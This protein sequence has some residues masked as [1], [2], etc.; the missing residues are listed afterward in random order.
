MNF[1]P[2]LRLVYNYLSV[3][4]KT[5]QVICRWTSNTYNCYYSKLVIACSDNTIVTFSATNNKWK[6]EIKLKIMR[7]SSRNQLELITTTNWMYWLLYTLIN[8]SHYQFSQNSHISSIDFHVLLKIKMIS[9]E[10]VFC[11]QNKKKILVGF[12]ITFFLR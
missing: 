6:C 12:D 4:R 8:S 3:A 7:F 2:R 11:A 1:I 5:Q 10:R 9:S